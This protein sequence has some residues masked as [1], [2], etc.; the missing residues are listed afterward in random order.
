MSSA[1][2]PRI[3]VRHL[4]LV[5]IAAIASVAVAQIGSA[6]KEIVQPLPS[7]KAADA[8]R[9]GF[10]NWNSVRDRVLR[11]ADSSILA[12]V[13]Q[14][15]ALRGSDSLN[16]DS[17]ASFLM[18]H[19]GWPGED[20]MRRIAENAIDPNRDAPSRIVAYFRQF[21]PQSATA[22]ARFAQALAAT[23]RMDEAR[24]QARLAW[25]HGALNAADEARFL[26]LFAS[27]LDTEDQEAHADAA[28]WA[29]NTAAAERVLPYLSPAMRP[30]ME[31]R[32]ALQRGA[33]DAAAR[34]QAAQAAGRG[35]A[36]FIADRAMWLRDNGNSL[37]ARSLLA[38]R[39]AL[40]G[41]PADVE[42][43]YEV[44]L[45]NAR[46]AANDAQWSLAYRIASRLDDAYAPGVDVRDRPIGE[47]DDY[48]SLAW[49]AG[50][51]AFYQLHAP[52]DAAA[53]FARY[54]EGARSPQV[55]AKGWYWAG[56]SA[57]NS[58]DRTAA[59]AD[60]ARAAAYP[61]QYYGQLARERLGQPI[62]AP[63]PIAQQ[64]AVTQNDRTAFEAGS[65][66]RAARA[67]GAAGRWQDQ[68]LFLRAIAANVV[69]DADRALA[70]DL[71]RSIG[72]PDLGVMV[73]RRARPN[74]QS[75]YALASFPS[76]SVPDGHQ[77][78][79]T[80]IH[81]ISRQESQFDKTAVSH[82]GARGLMQLMPG[83][84]RETAGRVGL[85]YNT[86]SLTQD[87]GYNV[88]LGSTYF[89]RMLGYYNGSYPLAVAAYNAGPGNVNKWLRAN[90]DPRQPGGDILRWI[91]DI[92]IYET[93]NYVQRVLE[94]AVVYDAIQAQKTGT[95]LPS[96]PLS[97]Y[98]GKADAG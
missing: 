17:Y 38:D 74:G 64:V 60:L 57:L 41:R 51:T 84:A 33:P 94:N 39:E 16:F 48:T 54:A 22:G 98:L 43:W 14:W 2:F 40:T 9:G 61:D 92:P 44:L 35:H 19:P 3:R 67:L 95:A 10:D 12:T 49:L 58:G 70:N 87:T 23:G 81:A 30:V 90:G 69:T 72:R 56:R 83:T 50:T 75:G 36:G 91:E 20:R 73:G 5:G 47:R 32:I 88:Q 1:A 37:L 34:L 68:S 52:R 11:T 71:S 78:N 13:D 89:Q 42:K 77:D 76:I 55:M 86:D 46:A 85:S 63:Q 8:P 6:R 62:V 66:V 4:P 28:L 27:V 21:P 29:R 26:G 80:M 15:K 45:T 93:R 97:R 53:M 96:A 24:D 18:G 25:R 7:D 82:A 59:N 31:A 79:W 65:L